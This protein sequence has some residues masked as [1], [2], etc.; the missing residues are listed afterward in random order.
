MW[1]LWCGKTP[2]T[3]FKTRAWPWT[4]GHI[5]SRFLFIWWLHLQ[6]RFLFFRFS[7]SKHFIHPKRPAWNHLDDPQE[8][9]LWRQPGADW[10]LP[11]PWVSA[12]NTFIIIILFLKILWL[13]RQKRGRKDKIRTNITLNLFY[14]TYK[15]FRKVFK[16]HWLLVRQPHISSSFSQKLNEFAVRLIWAHIFM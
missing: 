2:A 3:G 9:W 4:V 7:V 16:M 8:V 6:S 10:Q 12:F 13:N 14:S 11:V 5:T 1:R 15:Q